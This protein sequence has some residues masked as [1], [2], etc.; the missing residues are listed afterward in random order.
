MQIT[1]ETSV[2]APVQ[3][4]W[5]VFTDPEHIVKWNSPSPDWHTPQAE[6]DLR[7]G[8]RFLSRMEAKDGS[9]GF[10][11]AGTYDEVVPHKLIRYS[12][13]DG[14]KASVEFTEA[15]GAT[16]VVT[17]FDPESEN[18]PEVQRQGWQAI[19]DNF[20]QYVEAN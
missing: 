11:F 6:N 5:T 9:A 12:M 4:V 7:A 17:T 3:K 8:G 15:G 19:L 13:D 16:R 20:K 14:R 2:G 18:P 1:V 10:D